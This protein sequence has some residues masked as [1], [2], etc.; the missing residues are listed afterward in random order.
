METCHFPLQ[1]GM[2]NAKKNSGRCRHVQTYR[3]NQSV[4]SAE[5]H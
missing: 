1:Y 2:I 3:Y 5:L 4:F